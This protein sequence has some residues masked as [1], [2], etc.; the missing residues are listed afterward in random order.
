MDTDLSSLPH[1]IILPIPHL[2]HIAAAKEITRFNVTTVYI[3]V[4]W[5][6]FFLELQLLF[7]NQ[8]SCKSMM[9][10]I[11]HLTYYFCNT[12]LFQSYEAP[13]TVVW[14]VFGFLFCFVF[15]R[16]FCG[17][18]VFFVGGFFFWLFCFGVAFLLVCLGLFC[19]MGM[20]KTDM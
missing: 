14:G 13:E 16:F 11:C 7:F 12:F 15:C 8:C 19:F 10:L 6:F 1:Y 4:L 2:W 18:G 17:F 3:C 20:D 9:L 5:I